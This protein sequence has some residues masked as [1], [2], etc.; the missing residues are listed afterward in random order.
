MASIALIAEGSAESTEPDVKA[1]LRNQKFQETG[2]A[3][4]NLETAI[5]LSILSY[6]ANRPIQPQVIQPLLPYFL[7]APLPLQPPPSPPPA[8]PP[9]ADN[10]VKKTNAKK[11]L[12]ER[13]VKLEAPTQTPSLPTR[14]ITR[15]MHALPAVSEDDSSDG[16]SSDASGDDSDGGRD[17]DLTK[18]FIERAE[19]TIRNGAKF[20]YYSSKAPIP[21]DKP[22]LPGKTKLVP[23]D[24]YVHNNTRSN[25]NQVWVAGKS[26]KWVDATHQVDTEKPHSHPDK[27]IEKVLILKQDGS[28]NWVSPRY[29][30]N[31]V[32]GS[33]SGSVKGN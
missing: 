17:F 25:K 30:H 21:I 26:G 2:V 31:L 8:S 15:A 23:G 19:R 32:S 5:R 9:L 6:Q 10:G 20:V 24:V 16:G 18:M 3:L 11:L 28:P 7:N 22:I 29:Q 27:G 1:L 33:A 4:G 13:L 14:R 12:V